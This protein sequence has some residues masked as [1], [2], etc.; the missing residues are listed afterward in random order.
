MLEIF[1][2]EM[3]NVL[4]NVE[5]Y[6]NNQYQYE[7]LDDQVVHNMAEFVDVATDYL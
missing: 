1:F 2:G 6:F 3:E 7:W 4:H 5:T